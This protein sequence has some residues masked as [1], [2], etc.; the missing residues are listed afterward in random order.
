MYKLMLVAATLLFSIKVIAVGSADNLKQESTTPLKVMSYNVLYGF[1]HGKQIDAGA[2]WI[3]SQSVD[4]LAL[5]EMYKFTPERLSMLAKRWGHQHSYYYKRK[6]GKGISLAFTSKFPI[7]DVQ[8]LEEGV[9]RGF[10]LLESGGIHFI[11]VHL[12]SQRL[13]DRQQESSYISSTI[14]Q[15][16]EAG[17][18]LV[19]LG[20]FNAMSALDHQRHSNMEIELQA[21]RDHPKKRLN[22][23][24]NNFD[25]SILKSYYE[26]GLYDSTYYQLIDSDKKDKLI[27]TWPSMAVKKVTS[28]EIQQQRFM[29]IDYI[30]T[31]QNLVDN[32]IDADVLNRSDAQVLDQISDHYPVIMKLKYSSSP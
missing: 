22:L 9:N 29:R 1:N 3:A 15:L 32:I 19:V 11:V 28:K 20:D 8:I 16:I 13:G 14:K 12:T 10:L 18:K 21:M 2:K 5:Q 4:F 24:A 23:N 7:N 25:T 31:S 6:P 26:L 17:E 30:L 27:G